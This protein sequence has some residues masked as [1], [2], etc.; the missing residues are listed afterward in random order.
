M[1]EVIEFYLSLSTCMLIA[2]VKWRIPKSC[3]SAERDGAILESG[4]PKNQLAQLKKLLT[5][6]KI[7]EQ[8]Y[9]RTLK[10]FDH[11]KWLKPDI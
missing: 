1:F 4:A 3:R 5:C 8:I 9:F 11:R 2:L 10:N 6:F 7:S